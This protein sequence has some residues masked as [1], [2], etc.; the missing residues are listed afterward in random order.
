MKVPGSAAIEGFTIQPAKAECAFTD[1][2]TG[3]S[4]H[5]GRLGM[6]DLWLKAAPEQ[7]LLKELETYSRDIKTSFRRRGGV[8]SVLME[9][10]FK[11]Q[12]IHLKWGRIE[13][14]A[15]IDPRDRR[16]YYCRQMI[17]KQ[18]PDQRVPLE[19]LLTPAPEFTEVPGR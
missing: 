7:W 15:W 8:E 16:L 17:R 14:E 6:T 3:N 13:A 18:E 5:T 11:P 4:W 12:G 2:K 1:T 19:Q 10:E 9:G